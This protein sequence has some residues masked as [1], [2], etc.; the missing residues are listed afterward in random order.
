MV[1]RPS[2]AAAEIP[3][4][5]LPGTCR[6]ERLDLVGRERRPRVCRILPGEELATTVPQV[7]VDD[8]SRATSQKYRAS[9]GLRPS[10]QDLAKIV[11]GDQFQ[12][13]VGHGGGH[14]IDGMRSLTV[15]LDLGTG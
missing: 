3:W 8:V 9:G 4:T 6:D 11:D 15:N 1:T 2:A 14:I 10:G 12:S 13:A 5:P 7:G